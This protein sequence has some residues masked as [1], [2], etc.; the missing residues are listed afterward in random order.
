MFEIGSFVDND[1]GEGIQDLGTV[2]VG[3]GYSITA[4]S[5]FT[6][7]GAEAGADVAAGGGA[8][9]AA[10]TAVSEMG[11]LAELFGG[12]SGLVTASKMLSLPTMGIKSPGAQIITQKI[13]TYFVGKSVK[14]P[15]Q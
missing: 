4:A 9:Y 8:V 10:G 3:A 11:N 7:V 13:L 1:L 6:G 14:D 2:G 5:W 12:Q 15:C